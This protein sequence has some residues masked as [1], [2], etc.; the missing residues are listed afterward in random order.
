MM[1]PGGVHA[2]STCARATSTQRSCSA[3]SLVPFLSSAVAVSFANLPRQ[4]RPAQG[5][6]MRPN[7]T[8]VKVRGSDGDSGARSPRV[9]SKD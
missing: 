6:S 8:L 9:R 4:T 2:R 5:P 1:S 3:W 7:E